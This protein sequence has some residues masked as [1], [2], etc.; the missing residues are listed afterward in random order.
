M[1]EESL[2]VTIDRL[3]I[4]V[5]KIEKDLDRIRALSAEEAAVEYVNFREKYDYLDSVFGRLTTAKDK[6]SREIIPRIFEDSHHDQ[7]I[8]LK[9]GHRVT[10]QYRLTAS[11]KNK[12]A[13]MKWLQDN[14]LGDLIQPTV[15]ASTLAAVARGMIEEKNESLP[16]E[17]FTVSNLPTTSVTRK[18]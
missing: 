5:G 13:A 8:N 7:S 6:L 11:M 9:T 14:G 17:Y 16:D 12:E 1:Q 3:D 2:H 10:V 18:K 15:N 4:Q